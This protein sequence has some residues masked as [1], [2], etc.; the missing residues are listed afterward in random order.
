MRPFSDLTDT[1]LGQEAQ[2]GALKCGCHP[3]CGIGTILFVNKRTKKMVP[4]NGLH[5]RPSSSSRTMQ[6]VT[7]AGAQ[8]RWVILAETAIALLK[9]FDARGAPEECSPTRRS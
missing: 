2:W 7:D 5:R 8:P 9:N 3:N 1:L 6:D 4:L